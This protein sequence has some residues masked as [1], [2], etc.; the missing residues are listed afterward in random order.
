[1]NILSKVTWAAM[2][3]NRIR[4]AVTV[5]G[6]ILSAAMFM[7]VVTLA[8]SLRD[9]M[10]RG[11]LYEEGSYYVKFAGSTHEQ[12]DALLSDTMVSNVGQAHIHGFFSLPYPGETVE[13][14]NSFP[15]CS[16]DSGFFEMVA[17]H[18]TE[19]R[20]PENSRELLLSREVRQRLEIL[21][22]PADIGDT[23][24]LSC[25]TG[26]EDLV[27]SLPELEYREF[28]Q[29]YTVVGIMELN[30]N[31]V[32][33]LQPM[34]PVLTL[35]DGSEPQPLWHTLFAQTHKLSDAYQVVS[36]HYGAA[37]SVHSDLL[38]LQG[39]TQYSNMNFLIAG[40][41]AL[42]SGIIM[43]G[44]VS[45]IYNAFSISVSERT[46]QFGI[47]VSVGATRK[48]L[49]RSVY[50]EAG[51]LCLLGIPVGLL[52]GWGGIAVVLK[53]L[54]PFIQGLFSYG[55]YVELKAIVSLPGLLIAGA[56]GMA[57]VFLSAAIPAAR[58]TKVSPVEAIRQS[59]DY[60]SKPKN[61][62]VSPLTY[63]LFGLPGAIAR[64]Y[65]SVSRKKYRSTVVSLSV[66]V[67]LFLAAASF[68]QE[69]RVMDGMP[70]NY[71][72]VGFGLTGERMR[73]L[74][75]LAKTEGVQE[76]VRFASHPEVVFTV[77]PEEDLSQEFLDFSA[78]HG[79]F[80]DVRGHGFLSPSV[81]IEYIQDDKLEAWLR[82]EGIDPAPYLDPEHPLALVPKQS[83][84]IYKTDSQGKQTRL[85]LQG[86][87]IDSSL[88]SLTLYL[89]SIRFPKGS[90]YE[91]SWTFQLLTDDGRSYFHAIPTSE[92]R[93][94]DEARD[95]MGNPEYGTFFLVEQK[96]GAMWVYPYDPA[97]DTAD[98]EPWFTQPMDTPTVA[99]GQR[100]E[101]CPLAFGGSD[102]YSIRL[103]LPLSA[104][105]E[106]GTQGLGLKTTL[107]AGQ[108]IREIAEEKDIAI[109]D[110]QKA[111]QQ[112]RGT[113][114]VI[115]VFSYGFII[116][117]S[118]I[119]VANIFNT[120]STNIALRR[121]DFGMLRSV[122][123]K[124]GQLY[125]MMHCECLIYGSRA[126]LWGLPLGLAASFGIHQ[127]FSTAF[128]SAWE[129]PWIPMLIASACVFLVVFAT[130]FYAVSRLKRDNPIEAI[131][132]ENL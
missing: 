99:L 129:L 33:F 58:A 51:M 126:L 102:F 11:L 70:S 90:P 32:H 21:D 79:T 110:Y 18:V 128:S 68:G 91:S 47:L 54:A 60:I 25:F 2:K 53:V 100:V 52:C 59:R 77:L 3:K 57:T 48:Q 8:L 114:L 108:T 5:I 38:M 120:I 44:S 89:S 86:W 124:T 115:D 92:A 78:F 65:Y 87:S 125:R 41:V 49:R 72:F 42:L 45:L 24:S 95:A 118:L 119:C 30:Q 22:I 117:I 50:F 109:N 28:Q 69:M 13:A 27:F 111:E 1:M 14:L 56:I 20:L 75:A 101:A 113:L 12:R 55:P 106:G 107:A 105:P 116:L 71:D 34:A 10:I 83:G 67:F 4:T 62:R 73:D 84:T 39:F 16:G 97:T 98:P 121:R 88:D 31:L 7:A 94:P 35:A 63:K 85:E 103:I 40:V 46:K 96:D 36:G 17:L 112:M 9:F 82:S 43:I 104:A 15:L 132:T 66:S 76:A 81:Q 23:L 37:S 123:L 61:L 130:M 29:S 122:G 6:V 74:E 93:L 80:D 131:R 64:K 19:G 127:I 26:L